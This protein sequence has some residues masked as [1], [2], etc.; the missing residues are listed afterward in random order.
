MTPVILATLF[1]IV[2]NLD[3]C[4]AIQNVNPIDGRQYRPIYRMA[5][6]G[7]YNLIGSN[8]HDEYS[9]NTNLKSGVSK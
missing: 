8:G 7:F 1:L 9:F 6:E 5:R 3:E 4:N 2:H